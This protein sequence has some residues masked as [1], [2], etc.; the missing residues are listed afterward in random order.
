MRHSRIAV[1]TFAAIVTLL[2]WR[3]WAEMASSIQMLRPPV[4]CSAQVRLETGICG[5]APPSD[6]VPSK[7][8]GSWRTPPKPSAPP[9]QSVQPA[10]P[11]RKT[12]AV[13]RPVF[14][15]NEELHLVGIYEPG[16]RREVGGDYVLPGVVV[17]VDRPG[18]RVSLV[19]G[20]Y[21]AVR[22]LIEPSKGTTISD[23]HLTGY[24]ATRSEA[25][26][27]GKR[28]AA[29]IGS[30]D[31]WAYKME[32]SRFDMFEVAALKMT[33]APRV[34]SFHGS[35]QAP[36]AGISITSAPGLPTAAERAA[37]LK[38]K[39]LRVNDL[40]AS[41]KAALGLLPASRK[42][43]GHW[44][45]N[46][47]GFFGTTGTK[48]PQMHRAPIEMPEISWPSGVGFDAKRGIVYGVSSGASG[49]LYR[50]DIARDKWKAWSLRGRG[51]GGLIYDDR[52]ILIATPG[53]SGPLSFYVLTTT[54]QVRTTI[55]FRPSDFPGLSHIY[56]PGN[57][58]TPRFYPLAMS[59]SRLLVT[60]SRG[61][62]RSSQDVGPSSK[63][64]YYVVDL[65][66]KSVK[67]IALEK[68]HGKPTLAPG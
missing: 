2:P 67:P 36:A 14:A 22:W 64:L 6:A 58:P 7:R 31:A 49:Y 29:E 25:F 10:T 8:A 63:K 55:T 34:A 4:T 3:A 45:F 21:D 1:L 20:S 57:D 23:I 30:T 46:S 35:Y 56:D 19:L 42:S 50:Y 41:F 62:P 66:E 43:L 53:I 59:G 18:K 60:V 9:I 11:L 12:E 68:K 5:D 39:S 52:G 37:A 15:K 32:S 40:P 65:E 44:V 26:V 13:Q 27:D 54:G 38:R 61:I 16:I 51:I 48:K 47:Q 33:G 24:R 28:F 17:R